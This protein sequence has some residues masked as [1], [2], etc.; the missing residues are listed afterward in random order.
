[1]K[2]RKVLESPDLKSRSEIV[3]DIIVSFDDSYSQI[4]NWPNGSNDS[5]F[6]LYHTFR[7]VLKRC[8][9]NLREAEAHKDTER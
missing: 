6:A 4:K 1:M 9:R 5:F 8:S 7:G 2:K 3:E